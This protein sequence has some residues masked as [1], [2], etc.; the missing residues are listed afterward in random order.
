MGPIVPALPYIIPAVIAAGSMVFQ[1]QESIQQSQR[2][3]EAQKKSQAFY[4]QTSKPD[5]AAVEAQATQ[6]RGEAGQRRLG[7]Y[8]NLSKN[9]ASRGFGSGSGLGFK[10]A[11]D[12]ESAYAKTSG[13]SETE[14]T[15]FANTRQFAPG[16]DAYGTSVPGGSEAMFGQGSNML[17]SALGMYMANK[18]LNPGTPTAAT[19]AM[20]SYNPYQTGTPNTMGIPSV[21]QWQYSGGR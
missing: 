14:L 3:R 15:K 2:A 5:P 21:D 11:A 19:P 1:R 10:G 4:E 9:L 7:S 17:N 18:M 12:I 20:P 13:E 16:Q 6:N 8:Q